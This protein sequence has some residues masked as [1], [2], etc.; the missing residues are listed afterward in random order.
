MQEVRRFYPFFPM[1]GGRVRAPFVWR[2]AQF[3]IG[4]RVLLDVHGTDHDPRSWESLDEFRPVRHVNGRDV[5]YALIPQ[6]GGD[7]T[8]T[9]RCAGESATIEIM[10]ARVAPVR[11]VSRVRAS[12]AGS[13]DRH[14]GHP[15]DSAERIPDAQCPMVCAGG[16]SAAPSNGGLAERG[17]ANDGA[18]IWNAIPRKGPDQLVVRMD[19]ARDASARSVGLCVS[20]GGAEGA[21]CRLLSPALGEHGA[22]R[23]DLSA[24]PQ[25]QC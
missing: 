22:R 17:N 23:K 1:V 2:G 13:H 7:P 12:A 9:H 4:D 10:K 21:P 14:V 6:G 8:Q 11:V 24:G 15:G 18:R 25:K 20:R 19:G 3:K 16:G 5:S